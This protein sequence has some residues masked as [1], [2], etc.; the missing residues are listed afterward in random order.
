MQTAIFNSNDLTELI[1]SRCI[2]SASPSPTSTFAE[3]VVEDGTT[4]ID[5]VIKNNVSIVIAIVLPEDDTD[6]VFSA[7]ESANLNTTE[8]TIQTRYNTYSRM[9][10]ESF[11]WEESAEMASTSVINITFKQQRTATV[12][13]QRLPPQS[14]ANQANSDTVDRG[15]QLPKQSETILSQLGNWFGV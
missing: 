1:P 6:V 8:L 10:I 5:N 7:I 4:V 12:V 2:I 14:V 11:P 9:Y 3:H 15:E 13:T